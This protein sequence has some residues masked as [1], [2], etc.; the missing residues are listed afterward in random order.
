MTVRLATDEDMESIYLM[1]IDTWGR[2]TTKQ[3]YLQSCI[4]S[5]KYKRGTWYCMEVNNE[6]VSSIIYINKSDSQKQRL[7]G[8]TYCKKRRTACARELFGCISF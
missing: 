8:P 2:H 7:R 4:S 3:D 6:L 5:E 1:G